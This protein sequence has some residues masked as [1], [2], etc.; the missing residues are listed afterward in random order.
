MAN[1]LFG[2]GTGISADP[3]LVEDAQDLNAVRNNL[4]AYYKQVADI[5]MANWG[6]WEPIGTSDTPFKGVY[7]GSGL[8]ISNL[9]CQHATNRVGLFK[10]FFG[11][12]IMLLHLDECVIS[13]KD[14]VGGI[15]GYSAHLDRINNCKVSGNITGQNRVG[16]ITGHSDFGKFEKCLVTAKISAISFGGGIVGRNYG[17]QVEIKDSTVLSTVIERISGSNS[18]FGDLYGGPESSHPIIKSCNSSDGLQFLG[19][20]G[21]PF[22]GVIKAERISEAQAKQRATYET[23]GWDFAT[24]WKID[25]GQSYPYLWNE[26]REV[27]P[28]PE[29][30][31]EPE[32]NPEP[33]PQPT[34]DTIFVKVDGVWHPQEAMYVKVD[35]AW[36]QVEAIMTKINGA[37]K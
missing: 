27:I 16:G 30:E 25:E 28:E 26:S 1:G 17:S 4:S 11:A 3:Y 22:T 35:G 7:N 21:T 31:P 20:D 13:G 19:A 32:P 6:N 34:E 15:V 2:G 9:T 24:I 23:I 5:D 36:K 29:P 8:K 14:D 18:S 12:T 37:W 10:E 33:E